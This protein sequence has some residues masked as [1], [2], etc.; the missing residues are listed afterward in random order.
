MAAIGPCGVAVLLLL[1]GALALVPVALPVVLLVLALAH[2]L[3]LAKAILPAFGVGAVL[4]IAWDVLAKHPSDHPGRL[5]PT[6]AA[7]LKTVGE[8]R[9]ITPGQQLLVGGLA[10]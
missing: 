6:A 9:W 2:G 1:P 3:A 10:P 4:H 8:G 7:I 5:A